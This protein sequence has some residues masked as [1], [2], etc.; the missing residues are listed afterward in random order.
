MLF[1]KQ[2]FFFFGNIVHIDIDIDMDGLD[3]LGG[4][5]WEVGNENETDML[6]LF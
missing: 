4:N 1:G 5:Q 2:Y 3:K 6:L